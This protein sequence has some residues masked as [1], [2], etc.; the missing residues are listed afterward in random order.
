MPRLMPFSQAFALYPRAGGRE[1]PQDGFR[2]DVP[3]PRRPWQAPSYGLG[4]MIEAADACRFIGHSG[5]G[6]SS[7]AAVYHF[8]A[9]ARGVTVA[10]FAPVDDQG[11]VE[12]RAVDIARDIARADQV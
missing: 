5:Q 12:Q 9:R 3:I 10:A 2:P 6:P 1:C 8:P 7:T 4:L 11:V